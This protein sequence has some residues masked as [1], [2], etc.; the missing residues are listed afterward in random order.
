MVSTLKE[1]FAMSVLA[2]CAQ[3]QV[4]ALDYLVVLQRHAQDVRN[5]PEARLP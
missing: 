5:Q 3:A 4:I 1:Q 2:T